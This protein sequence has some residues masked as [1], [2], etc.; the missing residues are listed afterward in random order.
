MLLPRPWLTTILIVFFAIV[1]QHVSAQCA[2]GTPPPCYEGAPGDADQ[3]LDL[4]TID[5]TT[6]LVVPLNVVGADTTLLQIAATFAAVIADNM[7]VGNVRARVAPELGSLLLENRPA[8]A[9]ALKA[10]AVVD[11]QLTKLGR[12]IRATVRLVNAPGGW[13]MASTTV[14]GSQDS[15]LALA[16][17]VSV[18]F[19]KEWWRQQPGPYH[20]GGLTTESL[21]ALQHYVN[22]MVEM[23][24]GG[25]WRQLLDSAVSYDPDFL[26]PLLW[27]ALPDLAMRESTIKSQLG[28]NAAGG[29]GSF[30][31]SA[32]TPDSVRRALARITSQPK[33]APSFESF[34]LPD[35]EFIASL[36][37]A[38]IPPPAHPAYLWFE[39]KVNEMAG[40]MF[41]EDRHVAA[42][43][44]YLA[45]FA[46]HS[47]STSVQIARR[48]LELDS[49]FVPTQRLLQRQLI[50]M[51]DT[52][53]AR[54]LHESLY[55]EEDRPWYGAGGRFE[56]LPPTI[57][58]MRLLM[59]N[60]LTALMGWH[61]FA[62]LKHAL[63]SH[64]AGPV[65][66]DPDREL[67][68]AP[69]ASAMLPVYLAAG[70]HERVGE[71]L[72]AE[73]LEPYHA[74]RDSVSA[75]IRQMA[76]DMGVPDSLYDQMLET[77]LGVPSAGYSDW[78][79]LAN[80]PLPPEGRF[81]PSPYTPEAMDSLVQEINE[82]SEGPGLDAAVTE[83][84]WAMR[85][86]IKDFT[87]TFMVRF[88]AETIWRNG[89]VAVHVG[90][91]ASA[92]RAIAILDSLG[93]RDSL[94]ILPLAL[95]LAAE[96]VLSETGENGKKLAETLLLGAISMS[97]IN[98]PSRFR[99]L[100]ARRYAETGKAEL[101]LRMSHSITMPN[102][103]HNLE[104]AYYYAP[105]LLLEAEI[106]DSLGVDADALQHYE[107]YVTLRED[108]D[109]ALQGDIARAHTRL[110][111]LWL[112]SGNHDEAWYHAQ[113]AQKHGVT[114]S[115]DFHTALRTARPNP[116][117]PARHVPRI[118]E[119]K[120]GV[121][122]PI[123]YPPG[124]L[125][126]GVGGQV[127][128][129]FEVDSEGRV[130][131]ESIHVLESSDPAFE[132]AAIKTIEECSYKDE[133]LSPQVTRWRDWVAFRLS[134]WREPTV[135][136]TVNIV[137][138]IVTM[139]S[140]E[141]FEKYVE[142]RRRRFDGDNVASVAL[143][144]EIVASAPEFA[145]AWRALFLGYLAL[146]QT[147][148]SRIALER[149]VALRDNVSEPDRLH[150]DALAAMYLDGDL[151]R[152]AELS[153]RLLAIRQ[154]DW[155]AH[156]NQAIAL[157]RMGRYREAVDHYEA[158]E[159]LAPRSYVESQRRFRF[160]S[161]VALGRFQEAEPLL[162]S[163][164]PQHRSW[165]ETVLAFARG[166]WTEAE[167]LMRGTN[168]DLHIAAAQAARGAV[169]DADS[170]LLT[171]SRG[172]G[173]KLH[174]PLLALTIGCNSTWARIPPGRYREGDAIPYELMEEAI[175]AAALGDSA[176]AKTLRTAATAAPAFGL[177][178][179]ATW[180]PLTDALIAAQSG[181]WQAVI[182]KLRPQAKR[183]EHNYPGTHAMRWLVANAFDQLGQLDSAI[184]Y[185]TLVVDPS[186][187]SYEALMDRGF[188][189]SFAQRRLAGLYARLGDVEA[190]ERHW[191]IFLS[192]FTTPDEELR[193]MVT[194]S[195]AEPERT[196]ATCDGY[197]QRRARAVGSELERVKAA[198]QKFFDRHDTYAP[199][200]DDLEREL[201]E[202][203]SD[204]SG[205]RY[206]RAVF[207]IRDANNEGW[208]VTASDGGSYLFCFLSD[209]AGPATVE[210]HPPSV[211]V[212]TS[213]DPATAHSEDEAAHAMN[214]T[215]TRLSSA[216]QWYFSEHRTFTT[217]L[218]IPDPTRDGA[219]WYPDPDVTLEVTSAN[220]SL[221]E[222]R[223]S[224]PGAPFVCTIAI[225]PRGERISCP[226]M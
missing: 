189:Y 207:W 217:D 128:L 74:M 225:T 171:F 28:A 21:P 213:R 203:D 67:R 159:A 205:S 184:A 124:P 5:S 146:G 77:E 195:P 219:T 3:P 163:L 56:E 7:T 73:V 138:E 181:D 204:F 87:G 165:S 126:S 37:I 99:W 18:V 115:D 38:S 151:E 169:W 27:L 48:A 193:W 4:A 211:P 22:G 41:A 185:F 43:A 20:T 118:E 105:A 212:C 65:D 109:S 52:V 113:E 201:A 202:V 64:M 95:G 81:Y 102:R 35:P 144:R 88:L 100:L 78:M 175:W 168:S 156:G 172:S 33:P 182:A 199:H 139:P 191:Q 101:A 96:V 129:E 14:E 145:M 34:F 194:Q 148:S 45:T 208:S 152:E 98:T 75:M 162:D 143:L 192:T 91:R 154:E 94:N 167:R 183:G 116:E 76:L 58:W 150:I 114:F 29:L 188:V 40:S 24:H 127:F 61:R 160:N 206:Y 32:L 177:T 121:C 6:V 164:P 30:P 104:H 119:I 86:S 42:L 197:M 214:Q 57:S 215:L 83:Q 178:P 224:H 149:A 173:W 26:A 54:E 51:G 49:S 108:A 66:A 71:I 11:G 80:L 50:D 53:A 141:I 196:E 130:N 136:S 222:A 2:D 47:D 158:L 44:S 111:W 92:S 79:V 39:G 223:A 123:E 147:D 93:S 103:L 59:G 200:M 157:R 110:A 120:D 62:D 176:R 72:R 13:E 8:E 187:L 209:G 69:P 135:E 23:R 46:G 9:R 107:D 106:L 36:T 226:P 140:Q 1:P 125:A 15:L 161:L 10:G 170:K 137:P 134:E 133:M 153:E 122:E 89:V 70:Q 155:I 166:E 142:A 84:P 190:A 12:S 180:T 112:E 220:A 186:G 68:G 198:Q 16:D 60:D 19:L 63:S 55:R 25:G 17:R 85:Q 132:A 90:E 221:F 117:V 210:G 97:A 131:N 31:V 216:Q 82:M 218:E 174:R 179:I